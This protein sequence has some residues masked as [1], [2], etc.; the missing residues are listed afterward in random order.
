MYSM[1]LGELHL[2]PVKDPHEILDVGTGTGIWAIQ[3]ADKFPD[4]Q[5]TGTDL[6]PI[7]PDLVPPNCLF[8]I[9]DAS[10]EWTWEENHF[11]FVHVRELFGSIADWDLFFREALRCIAPGGHLEI[12]EH[13]TWPVNENFVQP[14]GA[15]LC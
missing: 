3:M 9:D 11:D 15:H 5:I 10:L 12:V 1:T 13:S 8:E 4:A 7:Q 14:L 2:A 6:S